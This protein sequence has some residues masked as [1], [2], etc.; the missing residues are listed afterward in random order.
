MLKNKLGE[1]NQ[2][3]MITENSKDIL[4]NSSSEMINNTE[5]PTAKVELIFISEHVIYRTT[6]YL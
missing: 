5:M 2:S 6:H 3:S 4:K 1:Q